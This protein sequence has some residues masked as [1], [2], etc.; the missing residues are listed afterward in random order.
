MPADVEPLEW[1]ELPQLMSIDEFRRFTRQG[2]RQ[3]RRTAKENNLEIRLGGT[4]RVAK[5]ALARYLRDELGFE[6]FEISEESQGDDTDDVV[7]IA[8]LRSA[9]N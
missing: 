9:S 4:I 5:P 7:D 8:E 2:D 6:G 3:A 1:E